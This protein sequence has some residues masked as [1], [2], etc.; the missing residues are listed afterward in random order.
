MMRAMNRWKPSL[1]LLTASLLAPPVLARGAQEA[2]PIL[3]LREREALQ[4]AWLETRL[5]TIAPAIMREAGIDLWIVL[6]REY[7][8][9]PVIETMLPAGWMSARRRT[10][11]LLHTPEDGPPARMAVARYDIGR[12]FASAWDKDE[13][14]DQWK[15]LGQVVAELDPKRI[16]ID[17]DPVFALGDGLTASQ[18]GELVRALGPFAERLTTDHHLPIRWLETRIPAEMELYPTICAIAHRIIADGFTREVVVPGETTTAD[19]EWWY[20]ERIAGW[21]LQTWFHPSVS[22]QRVD[23]GGTGE[24]ASHEGAKTIERGDLLHVDFGITYL[25]LNTDTQQHAYVLDEGEEDAPDGLKAALAT[26]NRLQDILMGAYVEG[27]TGNQILSASLERARREGIE[28]TIYTHPLGF[29]G[30]AAGP[31]IGL[32]DQQ[33]GV[34]GRGDYPLHPDTAYSIELNAA[35]TIPEWDGE[36]IRIML[37]EDAYFDGEACRFIDGRQTELHLI[38]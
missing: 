11:L 30:H 20:R 1:L 6:A 36:K 15:R 2:P 27:R 26:G 23:A 29:H 22:L 8:E 35:V 24:F 33:G 7:T 34:P 18:H 28:A 21:K 13:E 5:D 4:D 9:D 31:T 32:W 14:P 19:L 12:F 37:E 10:I 17:V 25:G 16:A 3:P 38:P